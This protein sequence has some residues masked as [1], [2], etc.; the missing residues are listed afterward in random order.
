MPARSEA[1]HERMANN[2]SIYEINAWVWLDTLSSRYRRPI[3]LQSVPDEEWDALGGL[4]STRFGSWASGNAV[5]GMRI[6]N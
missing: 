2:P 6:A 5:R 3:T 1:G 4:D